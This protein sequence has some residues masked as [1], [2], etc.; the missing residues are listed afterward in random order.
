MPIMIV[1]YFCVGVPLSYYNAFILNDGT[2]DCQDSRFCGTASLVA[3]MTMGTWIH[4]ILLLVAVLGTINWRK[5]VIKA[6]ER[7]SQSHLKKS[8]ELFSHEQ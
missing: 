2:T 8:V 5:E 3:G 4:F 6:Q 7:V 1:S